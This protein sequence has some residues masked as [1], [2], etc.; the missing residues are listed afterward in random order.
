[1][2]QFGVVGLG[3]FGYSLATALFKLGHQ[4]LA[5][6]ENSKKIELIKDKVTHAVVA[7]VRDRD[8]L[9]EFLSSNIDAVIVSLGHRLEASI[10]VTLYLK[11]LGIKR[12]IVKAINEDHGQVLELIGASEVIYPEKEVATRLAQRL[13]IPNLIEHIPLAP[14]YSIVEMA[15]PDNFVGKLLRE[16]QLRSRYGVQVIAIKDVLLNTFD[17]IPGGNV[18]IKPDTVLVLIGKESDINKLRV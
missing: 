4:V 10:L 6:D 3:N 12:I 7:D 13:T 15:S 17:L 1:M 16:L 2:G 9:S 18:K 8:V 11:H 5:I 14:E